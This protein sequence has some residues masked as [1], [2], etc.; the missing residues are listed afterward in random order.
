MCRPTQ[1][2]STT[3]TNNT[4]CSDGLQVEAEPQPQ[5]LQLDDQGAKKSVRFA[6]DLEQVELFHWGL[7]DEER[8][9]VWMTN[10]DYRLIKVEI[11]DTVRSTSLT[12]DS[13]QQ[14]QVHDAQ[15]CWRGLEFLKNS[16]GS[17]SRKDRRLKHMKDVLLHYRCLLKKTARE[18]HNLMLQLGAFSVHLSQGAQVRAQ[19][20]ASG[21]C[22]DARQVYQESQFIYED[23]FGQD[24]QMFSTP[25]PMTQ[26]MHH[27]SQYD[28]S[29]SSF[30]SS[31]CRDDY[32]SEQYQLMAMPF[33]MSPLLRFLLPCA[34]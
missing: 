2:P 28:N 5:E 3:T 4:S 10:E 17:P 26:S 33:D 24:V 21:D 23:E 6:D 13:Q 34:F 12:G 31:T 15:Y 22:I 11:N 30:S 32:Y 14:Q 18:P 27:E 7:T 9:R 25:P 19:A 29:M 1:L 20:M 8:P 16:D